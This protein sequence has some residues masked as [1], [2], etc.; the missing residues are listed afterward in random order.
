MGLVKRGCRPVLLVGMIVLALGA[1][2]AAVQGAAPTSA[3]VSEP[4]AAFEGWLAAH[5]ENR[6][7]AP[8]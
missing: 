3:S 2:V 8:T 5:R 6:P 1:G 7:Y 4:I